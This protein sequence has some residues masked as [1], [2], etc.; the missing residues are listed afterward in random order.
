MSKSIR[1][2][3]WS[4]LELQKPFKP[5]DGH[6]IAICVIK[7]YLMTITCHKVAITGARKGTQV[8]DVAHAI[9]LHL[10]KGGRRQGSCRPSSRGH[11]DILRQVELLEDC[12]VDYYK[13]R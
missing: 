1:M 2:F 3:F 10:Q 9:Q 4:S 6:L 5:I 12:A 8:L 7:Y 13:Q 11:C